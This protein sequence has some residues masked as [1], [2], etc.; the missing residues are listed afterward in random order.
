ME[1]SR[2]ACVMVKNEKE[3]IDT[4]LD[5][6]IHP[7]RAEAM[8]RSCIEVVQENQGATRKNLEQLQKMLD[9][10]HGGR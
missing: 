5:I 9:D 3:F 4:C 7:D 8:K 1:S 6:L 2:G 10:V